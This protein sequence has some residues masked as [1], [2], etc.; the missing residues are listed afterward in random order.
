M[1]VFSL[2]FMAGPIVLQSSRYVYN[3]ANGEICN[4]LKK[5]FKVNPVAQKGDWLKITWRGGKKKGW[6]ALGKKGSSSK[7]NKIAS[8]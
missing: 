4:R 3:K 1:T 7:Q 2:A 6:I 8:E 5:G